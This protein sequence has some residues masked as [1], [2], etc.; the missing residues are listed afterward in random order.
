MAD[1]GHGS[2]DA[3]GL[4][5]LAQATV[6]RF[7]ARHRAHGRDPRALGWGSRSDQQVRFD[8]LLRHVDLQDREVLD[9]GCGFGDL[10]SHA[11]GRGVHPRRYRGT[12]LTPSIVAEARALHGDDPSATFDVVPPDRPLPHGEPADVVVALGL[13]NFEQTAVD[14]EAYARSLLSAAFGLAREAIVVD[15]LSDV[16]EPGRPLE[17]WVHGF[18]PTTVLGWGLALSP[19][20]TLAHDH[21]PN[22]HRELLLVVRR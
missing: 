3:T 20:V 5:A 8:A 11:R 17:D 15:F 14:T 6:E 7:A 13:C 21:E 19:R 22:P 9:W 18:A 1:G 4:G 16:T 12:D 2:P 10:L